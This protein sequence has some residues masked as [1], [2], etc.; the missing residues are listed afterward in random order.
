MKFSTSKDENPI[1]G[2]MSYYGVIKEIWKVSY[3][4]LTI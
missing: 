1:V 4:N 3:T 2:S